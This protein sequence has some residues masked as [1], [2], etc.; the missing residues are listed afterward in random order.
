[1]GIEI[2]F[3]EN[4]V[5]ICQQISTTY[6]TIFKTMWN[7]LLYSFLLQRVCLFPLICVVYSHALRGEC[8]KNCFIN[9]KP[10]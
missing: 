1:M 7:F 2:I 9:F 8:Q 5:I 4:V 3:T 10:K 6:V